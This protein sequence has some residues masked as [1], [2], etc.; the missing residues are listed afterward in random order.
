MQGGENSNATYTKS[1]TDAYHRHTQTGT[2]HYSK[3]SSGNPSVQ[4]PTSTDDQFH[5]V[6]AMTAT[7]ESSYINTTQGS[8]GTSRYP[9][10]TEKTPSRHKC[11]VSVQDIP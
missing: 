11:Y 9:N 7:E 10:V 3:W 2:D 4:P 6:A 8:H 1:D 5:T